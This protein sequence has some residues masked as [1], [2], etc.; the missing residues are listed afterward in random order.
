V[1]FRAD[2]QRLS[3]LAFGSTRGFAASIRLS[4]RFVD[5]RAD[6]QRLSRLAFGSAR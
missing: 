5:F 3:R 1:D 6:C 4:Q 2:C